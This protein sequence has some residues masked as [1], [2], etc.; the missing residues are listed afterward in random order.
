M[1]LYPELLALD[2]LD[3]AGGFTIVATEALLPATGE[4]TRC[5]FPWEV[6]GVGFVTLIA[7]L[8]ASSVCILART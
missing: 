8:R 7:I 6:V 5:P 1:L 3:A 4:R 2:A